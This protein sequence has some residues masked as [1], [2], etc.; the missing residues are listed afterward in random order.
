MPRTTPRSPRALH[1]ETLAIRAQAERTHARE[2]A[3]P[4]YL[5]SSF[6]LDDAEQ[7]RALFADEVEGNIYSRFTNPNVDELVRK[8]CLLEDVEDG[9]ATASGMAA[10][11]AT[12]AAHLSAGDHVVASRALFGNNHQILTKILPRWGIAT[13]YVDASAGAEEWARA[14]RPETRLVFV[15]T[16]SNPGLELVDLAMVGALC[17]ERGLL[18]VVDNCFATP[19]LQQPARFGADL[20]IHSATKWIDGQGRTLGGVVVGSGTHVAPIRTFARQTGPALSPFNAW[21]LSKSLETLA[22]RMER[23]VSNALRVARHFEGHAGVAAVR[24][25]FLESHPQHALARQQ[26]TAGGGIVVLELAGGLDHAR[27]FL[28]AVE[29]ASHTG[30]LGDARTIV[31]HPASTTHAKLTAEERSR[32]RVTPGMVRVSVGL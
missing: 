32:V 11:F 13:T 4:L 27:G 29:L 21:V 16:P 7:A 5:T 2:H 10:V 9:V 8:L 6:V 23:H 12:L 26:M 24:Y 20:V 28:D 3:V 1:P 31:T 25:P 17:R 19:L 30:N 15:E 18:F 22:V 14:V